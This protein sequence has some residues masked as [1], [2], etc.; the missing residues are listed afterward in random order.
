MLLLVC[1]MNLC[2]NL[3]LILNLRQWNTNVCINLLQDIVMLEIF[4]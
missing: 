3:P 2:G 1:H 4:P